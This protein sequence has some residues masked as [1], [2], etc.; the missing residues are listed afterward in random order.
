MVNIAVLRT[1]S[2]R[3]EDVCPVT[4]DKASSQGQVAMV[5]YEW[6][7]SQYL[8]KVTSMI[9]DTLPVR[10]SQASRL[11]ALHV[12]PLAEDI[13]VHIRCCQGRILH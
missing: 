8:G 2:A 13:R 9:D 7:D 6:R 5:I 11:S 3:A 12:L 10:I 4:F 1:P